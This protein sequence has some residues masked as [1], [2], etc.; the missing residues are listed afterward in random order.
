MASQ[1][2]SDPSAIALFDLIS[3]HRITAVIY[4][5]ARLGVADFLAEGPKT[6]SEL[7]QRTGAH[8]PSLRRLLRA[9][10]SVGICRQIGESQFELTAIGR[11]LAAGEP[12]SLKSWALMEGERLWRSWGS[13]LDSIRT[14]KTTAEIAGVHNHFELMGRSPEAV[15]VFNE[16][17]VSLTQR[18]THGVLAAYD[19]SGITKLMDVGGGFGELLAAVLKAYPTMRGVIFDLPRCAEGAKK[20]LAEAGVGDRSEF[21]SGNFFEFV[22]R[23]AD[24]MILKS[25]I[26]DWND[27]RSV[28]ILRNCRK[29]LPEG[30][31]LLLVERLMP[32]NLEANP[33]HC[34]HAMSDLNMLLGPGGR[35]RTEHEYRQLLCDGGFTISRVLPTGRFS[36]MEAGVA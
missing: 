5:A 17:M 26:H 36:L 19:F 23:G 13:L 12:Q 8:E 31:R 22:P 3:S 33:E 9:L 25:I 24:A 21:V 7:A 30:G 28:K 35:E 34:A 27:D 1:H 18:V 16:A 2:G 4:V 14:G 6:S 32:E 29:A 10:V 11:L 15:K 20:L